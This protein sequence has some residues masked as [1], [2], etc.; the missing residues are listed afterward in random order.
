MEVAPEKLLKRYWGFTAFRPG[1]RAIV[2][3]IV[4]GE[5][6]LAVMPT[7]AGKSLCYQMPALM[8]DGIALVVSPLIALMKDQ[9]DSLN[10]RG[11]PAGCLNS[12]MDLAAQR[13]TLEAARAGRLKLLYLAP[14]RFRYPGAMA[15]LQ[16][17]PISLLAIDEAHCIS[18]WGHDFRPD[19][20]LIREAWVQ[21]GEPRIAAFTATATPQVRRDILKSLGLR[22][23]GAPTE[24]RAED[25]ALPPA[26]VTVTG[27]LR[28]N[29]HLS[30]IP[31]A[32]M[33]DKL[34]WT[35][36]LIRASIAAGGA[37]I[38]YCATRKHCDEVVG[39]LA[40]LGFRACVYHGG[41]SDAERLKAQDRFQAE[42]GIVMV[43]TNAFGMGV[44]KAD[45]RLVVHYDLPG[46]VDAYYQEAG[47]AGRDGARAHAVLLFTQA[48]MRIYEFFIRVGGESLSPDRYVTWAENEKLKLK[49]MVRFAWHE[50]C[51]HR[52]LLRYFGEPPRG[53]EDDV[54]EGASCDNCR[55]SLAL[56][57]LL[58]PKRAGESP[59]DPPSARPRE[60][61]AS[62]RVVVQKVL[63]AVARAS[64]RLSERA[65]AKVLRGSTGSDV[66]GDPIMTSK[67]F[68]ILSGMSE[69]SLIAVLRALADAGCWKGRN[70]SLTPLGVEVMWQR[71]TVPL[72][73]GPFGETLAQSRAGTVQRARSKAA[74]AS[75]PIGPEAEEQLR[76][77]KARRQEAA[78]TRGVPAFVVASN[79]LLLQMTSLSANDDRDVWLGLKG[80]G[81]GNVDTLR[82]TFKPCLP[83]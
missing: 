18:Q 72:A 1:Q 26:R 51:R 50:G 32:K 20:Q 40:S 21:L 67:S 45:V 33:K 82:E 13:E 63:S 83:G 2:E 43:A 38:V 34:T 53:C 17:L 56:P 4:H 25:A 69:G 80:I 57:G 8:L 65:L 35:R 70:P 47:R 66:A 15:A 24:G 19:Y 59:D 58:R 29:L 73:I 12:T 5:P 16:R 49:A 27:F 81:E 55:D 7:G 23:S 52:A 42:P 9:V 74:E 62:E 41:L 79:R 68:G 60:L 6:V 44:D 3:A 30:V 78:K 54:P 31:I 37:A 36:D 77:L 11:I 28:D 61:S 75:E 76:A 22:A 39:R 64:G 10:G 48:D 14:E 71:A 46:T